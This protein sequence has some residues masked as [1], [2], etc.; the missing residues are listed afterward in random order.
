MIETLGG[1]INIERYK[2]KKETERLGNTMNKRGTKRN[3]KNQKEPKGSKILVKL[4]VV[5]VM[6]FAGYHP[7]K[8]VARVSGNGVDDGVGVP[9]PGCCDMQFQQHDSEA[10]R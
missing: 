6:I 3:Q 8:V 5:I 10:N 2:W 1:G 7:G 9:H 4:E